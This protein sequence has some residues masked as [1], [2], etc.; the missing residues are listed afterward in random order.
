M[1]YWLY[2]GFNGKM[3]QCIFKTYAFWANTK[4]K[5]IEVYLE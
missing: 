5:S 4:A 1:A 2:F 3:P